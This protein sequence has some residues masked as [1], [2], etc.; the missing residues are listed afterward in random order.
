M[1]TT[2]AVV[3]TGSLLAHTVLY[4]PRHNKSFFVV[5]LQLTDADVREVLCWLDVPLTYP[6]YLEGVARVAN[7]LLAWQYDNLKVRW[8]PSVGTERRHGIHRQCLNGKCVANSTSALLRAVMF[9][10]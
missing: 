3:N 8:Y 4:T 2:T 7:A 5:A 10:C 6:D 9:S 1:K